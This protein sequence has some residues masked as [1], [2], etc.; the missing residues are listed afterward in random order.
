[1]QKFLFISGVLL[2]AWGLLCPF[3]LIECH[4]SIFELNANRWQLESKR[5]ADKYYHQLL[6][7]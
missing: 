4:T 3:F 1:M 2:I 6:Y 7:F 5:G